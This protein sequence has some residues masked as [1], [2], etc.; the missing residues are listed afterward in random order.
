MM[1]YASEFVVFSY[2]EA[3]YLFSNV[4]WSR[5]AYAINK[6]TMEVQIITNCLEAHTL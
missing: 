3:Y 1:F 6:N 2:E 4:D 5:S